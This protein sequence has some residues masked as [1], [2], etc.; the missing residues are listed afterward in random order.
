MKKVVLWTIGVLAIVC[1]SYGEIAC[2]GE[3]KHHLQGIAVDDAGNIYWSFTTT[4][5]KTDS[6]GALLEKVAVPSHY[7]DLTWHSGKVY[8]A[9]NLGKFNQEPGQAQSWVYVH[10]DS[11][12]AL[13]SKHAVPEVVHGA[14]GMEWHNGHFFVVGGLPSTHTAN[15]VYEYTESFA[16]VKRHVIESGQ[17]LLGI[18]TV[19]RSHDGTWWFGCYGRP[20][21][22]LRT[23][24]NFK[25]LGN[26]IFDCAV[27][28]ARSKDDS[29]MLVAKN[30]VIEKGRNTGSIKPV[31]KETIIAKPT[32]T[33]KEIK[34]AS[35][36]SDGTIWVMHPTEIKGGASWQ[37]D[38][39][40]RVYPQSPE[41]RY[42]HTGSK[43]YK[44]RWWQSVKFS[45]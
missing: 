17:T 22:T 12:L 43:F 7:G 9:V 40:L 38:S 2:S 4:L 15:Y 1:F 16:F 18:Q 5:V 30:Q 11:N 31:D 44:V 25:L 19:C 21:V 28:I 35:Q 23:D 45:Y 6:Q 39:V 29:K 10:D 3:Y 42:S 20:A 24:D 32:E 34:S 14:G 37:S 26:H 13:L 27:G 36:H 8:V 33:K 41:M